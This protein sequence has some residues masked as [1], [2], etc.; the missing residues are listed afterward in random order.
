MYHLYLQETSGQHY[1]A[2]HTNIEFITNNNEG[3]VQTAKITTQDLTKLASNIIFISISA[4][5]SV[6]CTLSSL[7]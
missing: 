5:N 2:H 6:S 7:L 3:P 1:I 4:V